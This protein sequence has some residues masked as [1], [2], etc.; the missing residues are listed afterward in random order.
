[1]TT[2]VLIDDTPKNSESYFIAK[3]LKWL[4]KHTDVEVIV[5]Y[6]DPN[7]GHVGTVYQASNFVYLGKTSPGRVIMYKGKKYHDKAIRTKHKGELKPFAKELHNA[8]ETQE[9]Y[10]VKQEAKN[11]YVYYLH[12]NSKNANT[13]EMQKEMQKEKT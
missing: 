3:S 4:K 6:A 1:M 2:L 10:Y 7:Y 5:S 11:I 8:L 9:A 13:K 12:D